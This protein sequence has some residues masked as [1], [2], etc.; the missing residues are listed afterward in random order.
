MPIPAAELLK[1]GDHALTEADI[2]DLIARLSD[3]EVRAWMLERLEQNAAD[4]KAAAIAEQS[5][6]QNSHVLVH[7]VRTRLISFL[8]AIPAIPREISEA[9]DIFVD[10]RPASTLWLI[11]FG[12]AGILFVGMAACLLSCDKYAYTRKWSFKFQ[13]WVYVITNYGLRIT[14]YEF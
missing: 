9:I 1:T 7:Q 2:R 14:Y 6:I 13:K 5:T 3:E 12:F 8:R 10:G 11:L 4:Q